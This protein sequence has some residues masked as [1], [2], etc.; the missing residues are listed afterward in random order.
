MR[1]TRI[2]PHR[3]C[4]SRRTISGS[5][6]P[7]AVGRTARKAK[8]QCLNLSPVAFS[9]G[10]D[11]VM[12]P[13]FEAYA[14]GE[15]RVQVAQGSPCRDDDPSSKVR[16]SRL[17]PRI[18]CFHICSRKTAELMNRSTGASHVHT[19]A[20][21]VSC[22]VGGSCLLSAETAQLLNESPA[23]EQRVQ[24][25][26]KAYSL[27]GIRQVRWINGKQFRGWFTLPLTSSGPKRQLAHPNGTAAGAPTSRAASLR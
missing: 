9:R 3:G 20:Q 11:H 17:S 23:I 14:D 19:V 21:F 16:Y 8:P 10:E 6:Q 27:H 18:C 26:G 13:C 15:V 24:R 12:A 25:S 7:G 1:A 22:S 5:A 4:E 2:R